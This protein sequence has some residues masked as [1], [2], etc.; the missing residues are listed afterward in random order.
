MPDDDAL[1][2][3]ESLVGCNYQDRLKD[4]QTVVLKLRFG[5]ETSFLRSPSC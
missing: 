5:V 2:T 1:I 4:L 3:L